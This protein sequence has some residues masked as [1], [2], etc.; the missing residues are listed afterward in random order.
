M[1]NAFKIMHHSV[2]G[3]KID[4]FSESQVLDMIRSWFMLGETRIIVTPNAEFL[5][6]SK[7]DPAFKQ[8]LN[9]ADLAVADSVSIRY[10]TAALTDGRLSHRIT[11]VDLVQKIADV[12]DRTSNK[13]LLIGGAPHAAEKAAAMLKDRYPG[14]KIIASNPG[15]IEYDGKQLTMPIV[16]QDLLESELPDVIAVALGQG[17]QEAFMD[18]VKR[19]GYGVKLMIGI[20]GALDMISGQKKRAPK[21]MRRLGLEWLWRV[22]LEPKRIKRIMNASIVFPCIVCIETIKQRRFIKAF[23]NVFPEVISQLRGL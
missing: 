6:Q 17:K 20:G 10:A 7:K 23:K 13:I 12:C 9:Q 14:L 5:L 19:G 4:D 1:I 18:A 16:V 22:L 21:W 15:H 11:G 3:V 2:L 8:R